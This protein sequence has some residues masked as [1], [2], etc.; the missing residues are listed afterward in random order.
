MWVPVISILWSIVYLVQRKIT[1]KSVVY[2]SLMDH[3]ENYEGECDQF[4]G[5]ND[6]EFIKNVAY[7]S[8]RKHTEAH[9]ALELL[10]DYHAKLT[11]PQD[12]QLR[13]AIERVIR[14]FKSRL[15]QALLGKWKWM[16]V[17]AVNYNGCNHVFTRRSSITEGDD[18]GCF[19]I[20]EHGTVHMA[21]RFCYSRLR[22][23]NVIYQ[24]KIVAT[25]S[26]R[27]AC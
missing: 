9:R 2:P 11:R 17:R 24:A 20:W 1:M 26:W 8:T 23:G 25:N 15:F 22:D 18:L 10:E 6:I 4:L 16:E 19:L 12:K 3:T 14:I 7:R 13:L 21:R 27:L 5:Y